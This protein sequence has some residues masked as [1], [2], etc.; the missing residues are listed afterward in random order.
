MKR[1]FVLAAILMLSAALSITSAQD[2]E[3]GGLIPPGLPVITPQNVDQVVEIAALGNGGPGQ[4]YWSPDGST[5]A[6]NNSYGIWLHD[7]ED[8]AAEPRF[9]PEPSLD[10]LHFSDDSTKLVAWKLQP[11]EPA[12][13]RVWDVT[14]AEPITDWDAVEF[15]AN[16]NWRY[17]TYDFVT[18]P[19]TDR[20]T[21][22]EFWDV[23]TGTQLYDYRVGNGGLFFSADRAVAAIDDELSL[24]IDVPTGEPL[25]LNDEG[26][27]FQRGHVNVVSSAGDFVVTFTI[28]IEGIKP[29][30]R[31]VS[32][33]EII[34]A[35]Q[36][37]AE[38]FGRFVGFTPD[39]LYI[40]GIRGQEI[41]V[42]ETQTG[43]IVSQFTLNDSFPD[44]TP[45]EI[46]IIGTDSLM[47]VQSDEGYIALHNLFTGESLLSVTSEDSVVNVAHSPDGCCLATITGTGVLA[48]WDIASRQTLSV[49]DRYRDMGA[50][51]AINSSSH[52]LITSEFISG[53]L[54]S[55]LLIRD[56]QHGQIYREV[57]QRRSFFDGIVV[58]HPNGHHFATSEMGPY[59][60]E[61]GDWMWDYL[62]LDN[63]WDIAYS[64]DGAYIAI[65]AGSD[66]SEFQSR[67]P[68]YLSLGIYSAD[69]SLMASIPE[70][71]PGSGGFTAVAFSPDG[72]YL[73]ADRGNIN[74]WEVESL[75]AND[76]TPLA[77]L[78]R[79]EPI[80]DLAFSPDGTQLVAGHAL[81]RTGGD[82][83]A[84]LGG[85]CS[86][87]VW[88]LEDT[89]TRA[90][91]G[92]QYIEP[93]HC[94]S[95]A[96]FLGPGR[97]VSY[98]PKGDMLLIYGRDLQW[99]G[100]TS[101]MT[102]LD[103]NTGDVLRSFPDQLSFVMSP[104]GTFMI[105]EGSD[106]RLHYWGII[107]QDEE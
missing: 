72:K 101:V 17:Q 35:L 31:R 91:T 40:V 10:L 38:W 43:D 13:A 63:V 28:N 9:I 69:G 42:W 48:V 68:T 1:L 27:G 11:A 61:L 39:D 32:D 12:P 49:V 82:G 18:G 26:T 16:P 74:L 58:F 92:E 22:T 71:N 2:D 44:V 86:A 65:A 3:D 94:I 76:P 103:P 102:L 59:A 93:H 4:L 105:S 90:R 95:Y 50:V 47:T 97:F 73:A 25:W 36:V 100:N 87:V 70:A 75:L 84:S 20:H 14:T 98:S 21:I 107:P 41:K 80:G 30:L 46:T 67:P 5:L 79:V 33:G 24:T 23:V 57:A 88:D 96:E 77:E 19:M 52:T 7:A 99:Q 106:Q 45:R 81:M 104:D 53:G 66:Y 51:K 15:S 34:R 56:V 37:E 78:R 54:S 62:G 55:Q 60:L 64:P 8:L 6:M 85:P 89:L 83:F 29:S